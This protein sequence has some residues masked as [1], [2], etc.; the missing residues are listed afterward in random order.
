MSLFSLGNEWAEEQKLVDQRTPQQA[1]VDILKPP[2][3]NILSQ[4]RDRHGKFA[5]GLGLFGH[6][7]AGGDQAEWGDAD[8]LAE[9]QI[10]LQDYKDQ[11][12][13]LQKANEQATLALLEQQRI[14]G[15]GQSVIDARA[16]PDTADDLQAW[17]QYLAGGGTSEGLTRIA[18]KMPEHQVID[19]NGTPTLFDKNNPNSRGIPMLSEDGTPIHKAPDQWMIKQAGAFDRMVPRLQE[20]DEMERNGIRIDR[21]KMTE[22]RAAEAAD[23]SGDKV[24]AARLWQEWFD[25]TLS[26]EERGYILAAEDAGMVVLRDE[27]GAAISASEILRQ[28]N[29]YLMFS[30]YDNPTTV[31]QR[32]GRNR[33]AKTLI[34]DLPDYVKSNRKDLIDWVDNFDASDLQAPPAP[35]IETPTV[36][37]SPEQTLPPMTDAQIKAYTSYLK[38][39]PENAARMIELIRL[40]QAQGQ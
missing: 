3:N 15:L 7:L 40:T 32:A 21:S 1:A 14:S 31:R 37:G 12:A 11:R 27:S 22:L 17:N 2:T 20:L 29:Q 9:H 33:K 4:M 18:G 19:N 34:R 6:I 30:D 13:L 5:A 26:P 8:L 23:A 25:F 35:V 36:A 16:T 39:N 24:T 38:T 10:K 28:M